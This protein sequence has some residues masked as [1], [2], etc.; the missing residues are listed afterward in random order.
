MKFSLASP[1]H[2]PQLR[3]LAREQAMPGWIRLAYAR[4]PDW[5]AGQGVLGHVH[6]TIVATDNSDSV[7]GCGV[8]AI[9]RVYVDGRE[10]EIGYLCG[11][12]SIPSAR[13]STG[14]ARGYRLLRQLHEADRRVPAYLTTIVEDNTQAAALLTG[15]RAGLPAYLDH[16]RFI[17]SAIPLGRRRPAPPPKGI[18]IFT[19]DE[20]SLDDL[21]DFLHEEGPKRPFFPVLR[22]EDFGSPLLRGL[23]P[24]DFRV[25]IRGGKIAGVAA[26][27]DQSDF[28]QMLVAGYAPPLRVARPALNIA[29]RLAGRRPLPPPGQ[30]LRF[31]HVAFPCIRGDDPA[32]LAALLERF[33]ADHRNSPHDHFIVGLHERDPLRAALRRFPALHYA[34]RLYLACWEDG[35]A[36]CD[37]L[38]PNRIPHLDTAML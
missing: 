25:A 23:V 6:Q 32:I 18:E 1:A 8:R 35:R 13:R 10:T 27:W 3:R 16:G 38:D 26:A 22:R 33:H 12:R 28:R 7:V 31:F 15:G 24:G 17:A 19:G 21:L 2:E 30:C 29:L 20:F 34:S 4:E 36:F 5:S 37:A 11:L 9:R 14:L